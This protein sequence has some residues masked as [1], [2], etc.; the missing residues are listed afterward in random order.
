[1]VIALLL[2]TDGV[3]VDW[4]GNVIFSFAELHRMRMRKLQFKL[5]HKL[6][7]MQYSGEESEGWEETLQQY[8]TCYSFAYGRF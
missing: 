8:S 5:A 3:D 1:V 7:R 2:G 4:K 6:A